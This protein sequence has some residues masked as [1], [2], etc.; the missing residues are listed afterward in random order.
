MIFV[1]SKRPDIVLYS[2]KTR[3]VVSTISVHAR[4]KL[5][6]NSSPFSDKCGGQNRNNLVA[7]MPYCVGNQLLSMVNPKT[8]LNDD[9]LTDELITQ[10]LLY[11]DERLTPG[12]NNFILRATMDY[13]RN[14][15]RFS[16]P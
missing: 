10:I 8:N 6:S 7:A 1:T 3:T 4:L 9:N 12:D 11:G 14:T 2:I 5:K 16:Q 15:G 13:F